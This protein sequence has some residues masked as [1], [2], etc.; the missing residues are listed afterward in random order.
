MREQECLI[1]HFRHKYFDYPSN[2]LQ[3]HMPKGQTAKIRAGYLSQMKSV[4]VM[5]RYIA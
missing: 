5:P 4:T 2:K 3:P 1:T